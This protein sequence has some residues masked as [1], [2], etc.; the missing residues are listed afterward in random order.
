[1]PLRRADVIEARRA[2]QA[3]YPARA[4]A[5][6]TEVVEGNS[7]AGCEEAALYKKDPNGDVPKG[8]PELNDAEASNC[9]LSGEDAVSLS[10]GN[11]VDR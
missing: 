7:E 9:Q 10:A 8:E 11:E 5:L 2:L 3:G 1:M 6:A 4:F